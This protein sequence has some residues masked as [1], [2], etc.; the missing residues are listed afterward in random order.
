MKKITF[1]VLLL[2]AVFFSTS[3]AGISG[4]IKTDDGKSIYNDR[5][6]VK[7]QISIDG[8]VT[9][10]ATSKGVKGAR[11]EIK[12]ANRGIGYYIVET[13]SKGYFK[14]NDFI[15]RVNYVVEVQA[16]GYVTYRSS[17]MIGE[18][19]QNISVTP[20]AV[21]TGTV[22]DRAGR[23]VSGVEV[24][25]R[26]N[27]YYYNESSRP[28]IGRT[29]SDGTYRFNK[30][31]QGSYAITYTAAGFITETSMIKYLKPGET[32]NL[33]MVVTKPASV[34]GKV[35][36]EEI[37]VP[38][39]DVD[40]ILKGKHSH[41]S[42][43]YQDGSFTLED[44]KPG[45]YKLAATHQGFFT[46]ESPMITITEGAKINLP[47]I[48]VKPKVPAAEV[49]AYRYT[50]T[51]GDK[52]EFNMKSF[53]LE[54]LSAVIYKVPV[55]LLLEG[56]ADADS[57]DPVRS[58]L[59]KVLSWEEPVRDFSPY[60]WRYQLLEIK[61]PLPTGGYCVE[62]S[63]PG[64]AVSRKFFTVT[65][66]GIVMKRTNESVFIY[67]SNLATNQPVDG[68]RTVI[69]DN[70][71]PRKKPDSGYYSPPE[72]LED[73][74]VNILGETKTAADGTARLKLKSNAPLSAL[75]VAPDGSYAISNSGTPWAS[76][77]ER[78]KYFIYT[79]RPVY[80]IGDTVYYKIIG[81]TR[82]EK[83]EAVTAS[84]VYYKITN[85]SMNKKMEEGS[86]QLDEWGTY[87]GKFVIPKTANLGDF[88]ITAGHDEKNIFGS[89][90]FYVEQ[91]RKPEFSVEINPSKD[92]F[93]NGETAEFKVE[94][95]YFFGAPLKGALVRYRFYETMLNDSEGYSDDQDNS[96]R[97]YY[98][99]KL[100]GEKFSDENGIAVLKL[101]SGN[102]P[103]DREITVEASVVDAS[104]VSITSTRKIRIGRGEFYIQIEPAMHFF[105]KNEKKPVNITTLDQAGKPIRAA[106]NLN[107]YRYI[108]KPV[109]R[110]YVHEK[111][112]VFSE[113]ISTGTD[114]KATI[115]LPEKFFSSGEFDL[116]AESTD[117]F[118]N[119]IKGSRVV[120]I[121]DS[122]GSV[123]AS[124]FKNLEIVL[125]DT[126]LDKPG[127]ITVLVKSRF[128][129]AHVLL[130]LEG[131]DIYESK[132]VTMNANIV[133]VKFTIK[134]DYA[135]NL[136]VSALM[137]R[138][139]ALYT[140]SEGVSLPV[141]D[142][143]LD[144]TIKTDREK[145]KPGEKARV[146][147][148]TETGG[149][150][151]QADLSIGAVDES[152]YQIRYDH[153]P[154]MQNFFYTKISNWVMTTYSYPITILAGAGKDG[155]IKVREKFED[156]A[157]WKSDIRT[158]ADGTAVVDIILP[159]NLT[160]WRLTARGH[161]RA[162]R[163][164]EK[165]NKFIVTQDLI[166]RIGKPRFLIEGDDINLIGIVNSNTAEGMTKVDT[167]FTALGQK[168]TADDSSQISLPPFG[169]ARKYY[170]L[171]VPEGAGKAELM[172]SVL[173]G[174]EGDILKL[175][176]P[177]QRRGTAYSMYGSG[178]MADNRKVEITPLKDTADFSFAAEKVT[179]NLNP[180]PIVQML[181]AVK[182]LD[183]YP[184]GCM[185]QTINRFMPNLVLTELI[186]RRGL[187]SLVNPD[188]LRNLDDKIKTGIA[189]I[190][191]YQN[192][193]GTWGWWSG[194]RGNGYLTAFVMQSL[195]TASKNGYAVDKDRVNAGLAAMER[196]FEDASLTSPDETAYMLYVYAIYG[197][198]SKNAY[199]TIIDDKENTVYKMA[200]TV[201]ALSAPGSAIKLTAGEAEAYRNKKNEY[202]TSIKN[203]MKSDSRGVY[204]QS[205]SWQTWGWQG[206]DVEMSAHVLEALLSAG[207][208]TPL[209]SR[210]I[211]SLA[212]RSLNSYW[213]TTKQTSAVIMAMCSYLEKYKGDF[214]L[215]GKVNFAMNGK[216]IA[217]M[218]YDISSMK[219][220]DT[221]TQTVDLSDSPAD[222][223]ITVEASGEAGPD[224][225]FDIT[226]SGTLKYK[227][228]GFASIFKSEK[229]GIEK[230]SNGIGISRSF[231]AIKRVRDMNNVEYMVPYSI[232]DK[233]QINVGD[234]I[235]VRLTFKAAD[236]FEYL[237]LED[238]LPAGFEVTQTSAYDLYLP[239]IHS[240]RRDNRMVFF[241]NNLNSGEEY[242]VAYI[243]RA[244]L[245]GK[246]MVRPARMECMYEPSIQGWS[247]PAVIEVK[248][249][250]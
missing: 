35:M 235:L 20:E 134:G 247:S 196:Y 53:R 197:R 9:S 25:L 234:E 50:F 83:F 150:P 63:G 90:L 210:I 31:P 107:L 207:D 231:S 151:V 10:S 237:A 225:G 15:T 65:S 193:D 81:K 129:D 162:G 169:T 126:E 117:K 28:S 49:Y 43:T 24:S 227:D 213:Q 12:N 146:H 243:I 128:T 110:V 95:K 71:K 79:D 89:G 155:K 163:V 238:F 205:Y 180:S 172:Y 21:L 236:S 194:D 188:A 148:K 94:S 17:G 144:I 57:I 40:I 201:R 186:K 164:G 78:T 223:K 173:S 39:A 16:E 138:K 87:H 14:I 250:K 168:L 44:V 206:A 229:R 26:E 179:V 204:W 108:W 125:N 219:D 195:Y 187:S 149:R 13:D 37:N 145:Y 7:S 106:V 127:E 202:I 221:L 121:Y 185:E 38:A 224:V 170:P 216:K 2:S 246:F 55:E 132:V 3:C 93:I 41:S 142:T 140:A 161:D 59:K 175:N 157:F 198:W 42:S 122:M 137:Q 208:S 86:G 120:W 248:K 181:R 189:N 147:I 103:Y 203:Q 74:P 111:K 212:A 214:T 124:K 123:S 244:E 118:S 130:T 113:K 167:E 156:T 23:P 60:E 72:R 56:G 165:I 192:D 58:G 96:Q 242:E 97:S 215:K 6:E 112:P 240:E 19:T 68:A 143:V 245:P 34:S 154:K 239:F 133:P 69:F 11:V 178:N 119:P 18:G 4:L 99:V 200:F 62:I 191:E 230:L 115:S 199:K 233:K 211:S 80:R 29:S 190:Q 116:V 77:R 73:L 220:F 171:K 30:L 84:P 33:P 109:Q 241:F 152:I 174:K 249:D 158:A 222:G 104:N 47:A 67:A 64:G 75:A 51:P 66:V 102:F 70:T 141:R 92:F 36:I 85:R 76:E 82:K 177:V 5:V 101:D 182:F 61:D 52:L 46:H 136:Y 226:V 131:R 32:F 54:S 153:T 114:G 88:Y 159:D 105:E 160:T 209:P 232:E 48:T 166:A 8:Y 91:Y 139:R 135:P 1:S 218:P 27:N 217:E 184:Y 100:E 183:Q 98:R 45:N 176:L 228:E 22:R